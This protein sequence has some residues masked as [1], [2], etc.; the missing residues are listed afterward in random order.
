MSNWTDDDIRRACSWYESGE[1]YIEIGKRLRRTANA[2]E[3]KLR[4][5]KIS[6]ATQGYFAGNR[7]WTPAEKERLA[8]LWDAGVHRDRI[9]KVLGRS[10]AAVT[11]MAS[12]MQLGSRAKIVAREDHQQPTGDALQADTGPD[13]ALIVVPRSTYAVISDAAQREGLSMARWLV[14]IAR[15]VE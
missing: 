7:G 4:M 8:R 15:M 3:S 10:K 12:I 11:T 13:E 2:V 6:K 9:C 5:L 14:M 1:S